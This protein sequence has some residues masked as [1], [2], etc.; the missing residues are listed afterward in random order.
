MNDD[1]VKYIACIALF[2]GV[3]TLINVMKP[4]QQ[5]GL[6]DGIFIDKQTGNKVTIS[7]GVIAYGESRSSYTI[8]IGK[9]KRFLSPKT[10]IGNMFAV[11]TSS[12]KRF[13]AEMILENRKNAASVCSVENGGSEICFSRVGS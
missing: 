6:E 1:F 10:I 3:I 12:G 7:N 4:H 5:A 9:G 8:W 11:E 13:P 2:V